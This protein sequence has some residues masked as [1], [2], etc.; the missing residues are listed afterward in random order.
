MT[1]SDSFTNRFWK[2]KQWQPCIGPWTA[3]GIA[4]AKTYE[5]Y[6]SIGQNL[7]CCSNCPAKYTSIVFCNPILLLTKY[8]SENGQ[9][10]YLEQSNGATD[11]ASIELVKWADTIPWNDAYIW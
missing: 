1:I 11:V 10:F 6:N 9:F 2:K 3:R 4:H 5:N 8:S 7:F